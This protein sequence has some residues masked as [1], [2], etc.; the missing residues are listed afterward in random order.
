MVTAGGFV[1]VP[2]KMLPRPVS[3]FREGRPKLRKGRLLCFVRDEGK[4]LE[5]RT[6]VMWVRGGGFGG[7]PHVVADDGR[8]A[9]LRYDANHTPRGTLASESCML[10]RSLNRRA[11]AGGK[12]DQVWIASGPYAKIHFWRFEAEEAM[13]GGCFWCPG[14]CPTFGPALGGVRPR[15]K[16]E[17]PSRPSSRR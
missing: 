1:L 4:N 10:A 14:G 13:A 2:S 11:G 8:K 7:L 16:H 12:V 17:R 3:E 5:R 9:P 15:R 6:L